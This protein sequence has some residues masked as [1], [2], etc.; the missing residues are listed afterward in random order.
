MDLG[1]KGVCFKVDLGGKG[2]QKGQRSQS[3]RSP[4]TNNESQYKFLCHWV[5]F[6]TPM[7][8]YWYKY[9]NEQIKKWEETTVP[10]KR[11]APMEKQDNNN[12]KMTTKI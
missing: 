6:R 8:P 2:V 5:T 11:I 7:N 10:Y 3:K 12:K 9:I 1:G 4:V